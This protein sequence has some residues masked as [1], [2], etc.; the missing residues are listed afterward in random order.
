MSSRRDCHAQDE[1]SYKAASLLWEDTSNV[2][3]LG[4]LS[5]LR[6]KCGEGGHKNSIFAIQFK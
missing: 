1:D 4:C 2:Y 5:Q 3:E 6:K